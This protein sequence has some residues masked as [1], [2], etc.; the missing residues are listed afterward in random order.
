MADENYTVEI[1]MVDIISVTLTPNPVS[2]KASFKI[3]VGVEMV[4]KVLYPEWY[5]SGEL[6]SGE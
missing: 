1:E 2:A 6:Y 5:Y 3:A 4:K